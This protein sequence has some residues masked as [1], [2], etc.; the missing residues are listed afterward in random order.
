MRS[1]WRH[2]LETFSASLALCAWNS[3]VTGAFIA[4]D[5]ICTCVPIARQG[6]ITTNAGVSFIG[7]INVKFKNDLQ[8]NKRNIACLWVQDE[9]RTDIRSDIIPKVSGHTGHKPKRPKPKRPQTEKAT[10]RKGH[11]PK[12]SVAVSVCG[13]SGLWPY[14]THIVTLYEDHISIFLKHVAT[15]QFICY[16]F[17]PISWSTINTVADVT[18]YPEFFHNIETEKKWSPFPDDIFKCIF[19]D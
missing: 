17:I 1:W 4:C 6:N 16:T 9:F 12:R 10:N 15:T 3:L 5:Y 18:I 7:N 13:R 8:L 14:V 2:Q 11:K 19:L